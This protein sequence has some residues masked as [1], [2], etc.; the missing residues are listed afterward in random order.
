MGLRIS[1][2]IILL[3]VLLPSLA[4]AGPILEWRAMTVPPANEPVIGNM[5][6]RYLA[7]VTPGYETDNLRLGVTLKAWGVNYWLPP[8]VRGHGWDKWEGSDYTVEE[9]AQL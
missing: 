3:L 9:S 8:D 7:E 5:V 1:K 2:K 6:A 4:F